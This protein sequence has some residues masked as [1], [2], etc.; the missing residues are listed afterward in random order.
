[1]PGPFAHR[2]TGSCRR[3][4]ACSYEV[5]AAAA[6][7]DLGRAGRDV[8]WGMVALARLGEHG[9]AVDHVDVERRYAGPAVVGDR[10]EADLAAIVEADDVAIGRPVQDPGPQH[11]G[12]VRIVRL[13]L[14]AGQPVGDV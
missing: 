5:D 11:G 9:V 3:S 7:L 8:G 2:A 4:A 12:R 1:M 14:H 6:E 10:H 13:D